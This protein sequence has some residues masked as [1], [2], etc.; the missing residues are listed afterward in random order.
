MEPAA[1]TNRCIVGR[2]VGRGAHQRFAVAG[3]RAGG[4][5]STLARL[6]FASAFA[7]AP[8]LG[9]GQQQTHASGADGGGTGGAA[10]GTGGG[11]AP[12]AGGGG[13]GGRGNYAA[14]ACVPSASTMGKVTI[15][16]PVVSIGKPVM[17]SAGVTNPAR[18]VDG[19]YPHTG[20]TI[21]AT[22]LP[23]WIAI[24]VGAGP[25]RL[26]LA[27][28]DSGY[29]DYNTVLGSP[30]DYQILVSGDSTNGSDG[31]W[32]DALGAPVT[33]NTVRNRAHSFAFIGMSWVKFLVT[34]GA[35][36]SI[37]GLVSIT[38]DEIELH[39]LSASGADRPDDSWFFMGDSITAGAFRRNLATN[40][41]QAVHTA[42]AADAPIVLS[43]G[44]GGELSTMGLAHI[45][46]W[47]TLNPDFQHIALLYGTNDSWGDKTASSTSFE[48]N[49]NAIVDMILAAGR[50]PVLA[51][52]PFSVET[53][54]T[55]PQFN[56]IVDG[57]ST[58]KGLPCGPDLY[59]WFRDHPEEVGPDGV[60]PT[61]TGYA[62]INRLWAQAMSG[63][64]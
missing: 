43:G 50:V 28:S 49:M 44:I 51:R 53:P 22:M 17:A 27:W 24:Q 3:G 55:M 2:A 8:T 54:T 35:V 23:G 4:A 41:D 16:S 48:S 14:P 59:G 57:I 60:H 36:N 29:T 56:A 37:G 30:V 39:D 47:L 64:Y 1:S 12:D 5:V 19:M 38:L 20:A 40:F 15:A 21:P 10:I 63:Q 61:T 13:A 6:A 45:A 42:H 46:T 31:T 52:I 7:L 26:L 62:S 58:A 32:V 34:A 11:L 18:V 33:G 25:S 9:C